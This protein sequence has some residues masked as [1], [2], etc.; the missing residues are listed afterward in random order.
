MAHQQISTIAIGD[1]E[2]MASLFTGREVAFEIGAPKIIRRRVAAQSLA[3]RHADTATL[4]LSRQTLAVQKFTH[5]ARSRENE[6]RIFA[7]H[8]RD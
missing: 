4:T 8:D 5:R 7:A 6:N 2:R 3:V 1:G